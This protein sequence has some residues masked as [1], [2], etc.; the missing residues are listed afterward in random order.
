VGE[1]VSVPSWVTVHEADWNA[2][3]FLSKLLHF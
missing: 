3:T 2:I 1:L